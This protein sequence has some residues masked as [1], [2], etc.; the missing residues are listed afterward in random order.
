[1]KASEPCESKLT[2]AHVCRQARSSTKPVFLPLRTPLSHCWAGPLGDLCAD[3]TQQE[4]V[5]LTKSLHL[6]QGSSSTSC[7][8]GAQDMLAK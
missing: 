1:M 4:P 6:G 7:S 8:P 3:A 2:H 5:G